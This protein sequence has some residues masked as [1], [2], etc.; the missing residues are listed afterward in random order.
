MFNKV[1]ISRFTHNSIIIKRLQ[2][3]GL[4]VQPMVLYAVPVKWLDANHSICLFKN[5]FGHECYGCG[6]TRAV[7]SV[8]QLNFVE[9]YQYNR[10]IIIVFPLLLYVWIT[11]LGKNLKQ[12]YRDAE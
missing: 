8:I 6:I 11:T 1:T 4:A 5:L 2:V 7:I 9:A 3:I 12:L 10:L